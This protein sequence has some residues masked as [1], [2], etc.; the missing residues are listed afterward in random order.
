MDTATDVGPD[1][2]GYLVHNDCGGQI[3]RSL[4]ERCERLYPVFADFEPDLDA[5]E[6]SYE[7][8][9]DEDEPCPP[10]CDKCDLQVELPQ[11]PSQ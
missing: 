4:L 7:V 11:E 9:S 2:E 3:R 10:H 6:E 1:E 5:D 8:L